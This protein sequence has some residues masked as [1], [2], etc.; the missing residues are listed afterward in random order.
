[1]RALCE[2]H[3]SGLSHLKVVVEM[4]LKNPHQDE[5]VESRSG[6]ELN[7]KNEE[8]KVDFLR[9]SLVDCCLF[10]FRALFE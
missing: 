5:T 7:Q 1:L 4:R 8:K 10:G 6:G 3:R 9:N 2:E